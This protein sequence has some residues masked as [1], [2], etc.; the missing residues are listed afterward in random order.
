[1]IKKKVRLVFTIAFLMV[2]M[3]AGLVF[4]VSNVNLK[5]T[6]SIGNYSSDVRL[7]TRSGSITGLDVYDMLAP[8][9]PSNYASFYSSVSS[10]SLAI[11]SWNPTS[12]TINLVYHVNPG[13]TG[14]L[15]FS[16]NA[17]T[18][19]NYEATFK[20]YGTDSSYSSEVDSVNMRSSSS[21]S[22]TLSGETDIYVQVVVSDYSAPSTESSS[23]GSS[24][25]GGGGMPTP[26]KH[27][28]VLSNKEMQVYMVVDTNKEQI[29]VI[30]NLLNQTKKITLSSQGF[31]L[32]G[33]TSFDLK[34]G[35]NSIKI[36]IGAV[37]KPGIYT[38]KILVG[39]QE[40]LTTLNVHTKELLFDTSLQIPSSYKI[41][42]SKDKVESQITLIPM[43]EEARL[44]V[45]LNYVIKDFEGRTWLSESETMLV[46]GQKSFKK[47]FSI[48][49]LPP[50]KYVLGVELIYP[51]GVATS[52]SNFEVREKTEGIGRL[53]GYKFIILILGFGIILI[54]L[55]IILMAKR[56]KKIKKFRAKLKK[57]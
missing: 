9:S 30:K 11:D 14:D 26:T 49:Q 53:S 20:D 54:L 41:I 36:K 31:S 44:D 10:D 17:V 25:G 39:G 24:G 8:S 19:T 57:R 51:N 13:Q 46:D 52:S 48:K 15:V 12:R 1:M 23:S 28:E 2:F 33:N 18:G 29:L 34:P 21:Y 35:V 38:G 27:I 37:E 7:I 22:K 3:N 40:I 5:I 16:W 42:E 6:G 43:G 47:E 4:A 50:G 32:V 45:T 55:L 56:Y